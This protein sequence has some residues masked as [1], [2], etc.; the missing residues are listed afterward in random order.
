MPVSFLE[1]DDWDNGIRFYTEPLSWDAALGTLSLDPAASGESA[2]AFF[3]IP[4]TGN[5][6]TRL[7]LSV[8]SGYNVGTGDAI[9]F[10]FGAP[11][12]P[13]VPEPSTALAGFAVACACLGA[14]GRSGLRKADRGRKLAT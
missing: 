14:R 11:R 5:A 8:P 9:E 13:V 6:V 10:A 1:I 4:R 2:F 7:T 12:A 3:S